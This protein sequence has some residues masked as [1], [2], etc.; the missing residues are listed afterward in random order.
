MSDAI[1][2]IE[3]LSVNYGGP[4]VVS[5]V[6]FSLKRG[7]II[8]IVG[9]SG[10]GKSTLLKA[11]LPLE[12]RGINVENGDVVY[13]GR[14]F[15]AL[16]GAD[17]K[18]LRGVE[19]GKIFQNPKASFNPIRTY[20]K[21]F[22]ETLISHGKYDKSVFEEQVFEIFENLNLFE[23][24][25]ILNS[26]PF[27]MSGGMNQRIAIA[28]AMM[29]RPKLLLADE[30]T[31]ALDVSAQ[32]Q[33]IDELL[34]MRECYHTAIIL[35]THN[36]GILAK[37]TDRIGVMHQGKLVEYG[38]AA[39]I[40]RDPQDAYTKKLLAAVPEAGI[41]NEG[42][43]LGK[44]G[45][46]L[47]IK[48]VNKV[49]KNDVTALK[50]IHLTLRPGEVKGIVGESGSGKSTLLK[51][52]AGLQKPTGGTIL[53]QGKDLINNRTQEDYRQIQMVFQNAVDSFNPRFKISWSFREVL[54]NLCGIKNKKEQNAII[55]SLLEKVGL[56]PEL[57]NRYPAELSGGQCQR[58]AIARAV[59]V[60]PALLLCDEI[61]SALDVSVQADIVALLM[62]LADEFRMAILF[63][64]HDIVLVSNICENIVVMH[65]GRCIESGVAKE[66]ITAP[67]QAYTKELLTF[68]LTDKELKHD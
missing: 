34:K 24:K 55:D 1:L 61:T 38:S 12:D 7:E 23:G 4:Q 49:F 3:N 68:A 10:S 8:G 26:C 2:S 35:V 41:Y 64:S 13:G 36:I 45:D 30:P 67:Q 28:M 18:K 56:A 33:V 53:F 51:Q 25:R 43:A 44:P 31:S 39:T 57:A 54:K 48:S 52:I 20:R 19:I 22:I 40:L 37:I 5:D 15:S 11:I 9:E 50:D 58:A 14:P 60:R 17:K 6:S 21:Q 65:E 32:K 66:I 29:L 46:L 16:S 62:E 27:E 47:E 42:R 59:A 63:V